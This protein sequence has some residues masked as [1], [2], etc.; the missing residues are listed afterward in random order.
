MFDNSGSAGAAA[1]LDEAINELVAKKVREM[2]P[3]AVVP[4]QP[5]VPFINVFFLLLTT[6]N[7][8]FLIYLTPS[9]WLQGP[10]WDLLSKVVPAFGGTFLAVVAAWYKD[11]LLAMVEE[12]PFR[13][14][15]AVLSVIFILMIWLPWLPIRPIIGPPEETQIM[16]DDDQDPHPSDHRIWVPLRA[17]SF[18]IRRK[19]EANDHSRTLKLGL[20]E[21]VA[22]ALG[23]DERR[24]VLCYP[25]NF[26]SNMKGYSIRIQPVD[27][28]RLDRDFREHAYEHG[29]MMQPDNSLILRV[30]DEMTGGTAVLP[31]GLFRMTPFKQKGCQDGKKHEGNGD[32]LN[33][34][35]DEKSVK[36][37]VI[38]PE[39]KC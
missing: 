8:A 11:R 31:F 15:M 33:V 5:R 26:D 24:W 22:A 1:K 39:I 12:R 17:H 3:G 18:T 7:L 6:L 35:P 9:D 14:T 38:L 34:G 27:P 13:I 4:A 25:V 30:G 2:V 21:V 29:L 32:D 20:W 23:R 16:K 36:D 37:V 19:E 28:G 10:H